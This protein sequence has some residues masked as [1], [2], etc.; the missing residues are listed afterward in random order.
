MVKEQT[1][2]KVE[3]KAPPVDLSVPLSQATELLGRVMQAISVRSMAGS[4]FLPGCVLCEGKVIP[5]LGRAMDCVCND[6][7]SYLDAAA[8]ND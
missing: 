3:P 1:S 5:S 4:N 8:G 2:V 7:R 6:V